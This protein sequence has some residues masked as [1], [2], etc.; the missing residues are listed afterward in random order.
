MQVRVKKCMQ[1]VDTTT[2]A[3]QISVISIE[4]IVKN[5]QKRL[6]EVLLVHHQLH[7]QLSFTFQ[8][9][10]SHL[11]LMFQTWEGRIDLSSL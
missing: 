10:Q 4:I 5:F 8:A 2:H 7:T 1:V 6:Y 3:K 11:I 9:S